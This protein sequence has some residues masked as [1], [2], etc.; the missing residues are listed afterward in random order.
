[1]FVDGRRF[2]VTEAEAPPAGAPRESAGSAAGTW[3]LNVEAPQGPITATLTLQQ[4][5]TGVTGTIQSPM[6]TAEILEGRLVG[7][8]LTF[9]VSAGGMEVSFSEAIQGSTMTGT[10]TAGTMGTMNFTGSR[11][12]REQ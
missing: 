1:M 8:Q 6:G 5:G 7:N 10:V 9:R 4:S 12:P 11:S 2:E 3:T